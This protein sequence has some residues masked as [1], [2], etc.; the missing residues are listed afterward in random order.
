[1]VVVVGQQVNLA[2]ALATVRQA[3]PQRTLWKHTAA[4]LH[5]QTLRYGLSGVFVLQAI[6]LLLPV[7][8]TPSRRLEHNTLHLLADCL[9]KPAVECQQSCQQAESNTRA[10]ARAGVLALMKNHMLIDAGRAADH[11]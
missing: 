10:Q 3:S 9:P 7:L 1:M 8:P 2:H 4:L 11:V 5:S 6:P